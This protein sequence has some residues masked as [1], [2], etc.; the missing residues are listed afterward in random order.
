MAVDAGDV[1]VADEEGVV[2]VPFA[3]ADEVLSGARAKLAKEAAESLD[4]WETAHRARVDEILAAVG[5]EG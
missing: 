5:F 1:V 2:V 4:E 3:R